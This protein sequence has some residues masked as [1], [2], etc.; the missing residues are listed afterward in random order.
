VHYGNQAVI[1]GDV[2]LSKSCVDAINAIQKMS[3]TLDPAKT[4]VFKAGSKF[5]AL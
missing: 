4:N 2:Q 3:F 1:L 5:S